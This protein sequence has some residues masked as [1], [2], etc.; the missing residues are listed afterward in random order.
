MS[1]PAAA[2]AAAASSSSSSALPPW[3]QIER[4]ANTFAKENRHFFTRDDDGG[5]RIQ[6]LRLAGLPHHMQ[7][8]DDGW[9]ISVRDAIR[10][11]SYDAFSAYISVRYPAIDVTSGT[12]SAYNCSSLISLM[13]AEATIVRL[14]G[15]ANP[16]DV[17]STDS[18]IHLVDELMIED[19][20][21][22]DYVVDS[23]RLSIPELR[24]VFERLD[25]L[26]A[27]RRSTRRAPSSDIARLGDLV[28]RAEER[29]EFRS[30][31]SGAIASS[32]VYDV[33]AARSGGP[34]VAQYAATFA[35]RRFG[36][37]EYDAEGAP[38]R[39]PLHVRTHEA[40]LQRIR[41]ELAV[42]MAA[43]TSF[44]AAQL[45]ERVST[46]KRGLDNLIE[47]IEKRKK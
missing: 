5:G 36:R 30:N 29:L 18:F 31:P 43:G 6:I 7:E 34:H 2:A 28:A 12:N 25:E 11:F 47:S 44:T 8:P 24:S 3:A 39:L 45:L 42:T 40:E 46:T 21:A 26:Y 10:Y 32:R 22:F 27:I 33:L 35:D 16:V 4:E 1:A 23:D 20:D 15:S 19:P 37:A 38:T 14:G 41:A 13:R 17:R 9:P